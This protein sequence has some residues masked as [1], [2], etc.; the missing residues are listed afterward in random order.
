MIELLSRFASNKIAANPVWQ[1]ESLWRLNIN[2]S[3]AIKLALND[4]EHKVYFSPAAKGFTAKYN[5]HSVFIQ[6]EL[7]EAHLAKI[8][9]ATSKKTYAY[10]SNAQGLTLYADGQSYKFAHIKPNFNTED[11]ASDANN[12]K[13]PMPGVIT[14]VLVQNNSAVKKDDVLLTL[15]AMKIE[16]SIRAPH[17]GIVSA[18]YFQVGEQVKAGD[19][20]VEFSSLEGAA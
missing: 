16:Y 19:K 11:D 15:E 6:G 4:E 5:G 13:A 3:Y 1:T 2:A 14:Q 12:L 18:A 10:S 17:D 9:C 8:E 20:L 7:L